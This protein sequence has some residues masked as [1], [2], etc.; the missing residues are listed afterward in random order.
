[1]HTSPHTLRP[2]LPRALAAPFSFPLS[3]LFLLLGFAATTATATSYYVDPATGSMSNPG[4]SQLPW[5]TLEAVFNAGKPF[6]AG[7]VIYLRNGYHG[8]P[9]VRG[10]NTGTVT[11]QPQSGHTPKLKYLDTLNASH[12]TIS[13]LDISPFYAGT[14]LTNANYLC[15]IRPSCS[16]ITVQNCRLNSVADTVD[17]KLWSVADWGVAADGA[18]VE[19]PHSQFINNTLTNVNFG[20]RVMQTAPDSLITGNRITNFSKDGMIGLADNC[21]FSYNTV[22]NSYLELAVDPNHDDGFQSW[23]TNAASVVSNITL[24]GNIFISCTDP[25]QPHKGDM[26]GIGCFNGMYSGWIVENNV[27]AACMINGIAFSGATNCRIVNNTVVKNPL[28][29]TGDTPYIRIDPKPG[30]TPVST[31]NTV[32]NN[33]APNWWFTGTY[34]A[35]HNIT[36]NAANYS[37]HFVDYP[38]LDLHLKTGSSAINAGSSTLAPAIDCDQLPRSAPYDIGAFE[39]RTANVH[40]GTWSLKSVLTSTKSYSNASQAPTG[41]PAATTYV[42]SIWIKGSGSVQLKV[43][44]GAWGAALAT[45]QC[46]ATSTWT[47]VTTPAFST[48]ANTQLTFV[49]QDQY[50]TAGTIYID[51]AFLGVSG[52]ANKLA[53]PGFE[54]GTSSWGIS[55][56]TI[57]SIGQF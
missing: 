55:N 23:A 4:T 26:Q 14:T 31:D 50:G 47:Q 54:S 17:V 5:S 3:K 15:F 39:Y 44:A 2:F 24:R 10:F 13:D 38:N 7:D 16:Y 21:E 25:A 19:G 41:I 6:V 51:D 28:N 18:R 36:L 42:G 33:F 35:D 29:P 27:V 34:T 12:W 40:G 43:L 48:D 1:M 30:G 32:R 53:N 8:A 20:I 22:L 56:N 11:I 46:N 57:W 45:V 37:A 49:L 52:G 9:M